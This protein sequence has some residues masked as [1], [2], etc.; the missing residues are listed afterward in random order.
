MSTPTCFK[1]MKVKATAVGKEI[2]TRG[3][4]SFVKRLK[5]AEQNQSQ[6]I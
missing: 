3:V 2:I 5:L 6:E 1:I 4:Q